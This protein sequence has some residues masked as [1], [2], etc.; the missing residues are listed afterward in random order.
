MEMLQKL[1]D[2]YVTLNQVEIKGESNINFM[3]GSLAVLKEVI[4]N[5]EKDLNI[6]D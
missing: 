2:V 1:K 6:L 3:Y 4:T 5:I